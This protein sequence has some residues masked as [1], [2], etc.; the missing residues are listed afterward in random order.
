LALAGV[1]IAGE[2]FGSFSIV[3]AIS[4]EVNGPNL[5]AGTDFIYR[6]HPRQRISGISKFFKGVKQQKG[7]P[8]VTEQSAIST[9]LSYYHRKW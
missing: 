1:V 4:L 7:G 5:L 8:A 2:L 3:I 6:Q 9:G